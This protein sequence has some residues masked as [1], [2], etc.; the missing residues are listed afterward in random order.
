MTP[1]KRQVPLWCVALL[2]FMQPL[3]Q[4]QAESTQLE[5]CRAPN[6]LNSYV[7]DITAAMQL[8]PYEKL[9]DKLRQE[10]AEYGAALCSERLTKQ[11][12]MARFEKGRK[13]FLDAAR[14]NGV[15]DADLAAVSADANRL[16]DQCV[17]L[18]SSALRFHVP[19]HLIAKETITGICFA[20]VAHVFDSPNDVTNIERVVPSRN[21]F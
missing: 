5:R 7:G 10:V 2:S 18:R 8:A 21:R 11:E 13:R 1:G 20:A 4:S 6:V 3:A 14:E 15:R 16:V 12:A 9:D 17:K 19:L